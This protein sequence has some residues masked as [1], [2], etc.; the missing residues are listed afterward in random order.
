MTA[1]D[2]ESWYEMRNGQYFCKVCNKPLTGQT[3][4]EAFVIDA[5]SEGTYY[6]CESCGRNIILPPSPR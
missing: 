3:M 4:K 1:N 2:P 6:F 5:P